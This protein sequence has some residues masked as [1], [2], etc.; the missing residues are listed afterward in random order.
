MATIKHTVRVQEIP[1]IVADPSRGIISLVGDRGGMALITGEIERSSMMGLLA[2]E[3]EHG[4]L[5]LDPESE[6]VIS[7]Q[8]LADDD[9]EWLVEW[10]IDSYGR[11]PE[12]AAARVWTTIFGRSIATSEDACSFTV[13]DSESKAAYKVDLSDHDLDALA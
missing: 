13:T 9:H 11:T 3:T 6:V 8:L 4:T 2:I 7:E 10:A 12:A 1:S 5:Y